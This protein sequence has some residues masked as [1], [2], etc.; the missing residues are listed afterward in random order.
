MAYLIHIGNSCGV[1]IPKTIINQMG[2]KEGINLVF[3]ITDEGLL[4]YTARQNRDNWKEAFIAAR[5]DQRRPPI[6]I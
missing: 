6:W 3:K 5:E 2:F 1:R 4:I